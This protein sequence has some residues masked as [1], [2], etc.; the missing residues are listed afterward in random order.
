[1]QTMRLPLVSLAAVVLAALA[2][3]THAQ[4][5]FDAANNAYFVT[6]DATIDTD[7]SGNDV[8]VGKDNATDFTTLAARR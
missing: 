7:I 8:F 6:G 4:I 5:T 3:A 1:M 2:P